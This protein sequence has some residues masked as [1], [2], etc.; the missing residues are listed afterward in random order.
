MWYDMQYALLS[1]NPPHANVHCNETLVCFKASGSPFLL[2]LH[3]TPLRYPAV[4][5][6]QKDPSDILFCMTSTFMWS[7]R[8]RWVRKKVGQSKTQN[9]ELSSS[10]LGTG[11]LSRERT[12]ASSPRNTPSGILPMVRGG[13][14]CPESRSGCL[15]VSAIPWWIGTVLLQC[16]ARGI[17]SYTGPVKV[18]AFYQDAQISTHIVPLSLCG[19]TGHKHPHRPRLASGYHHGSG[20]NLGDLDQYGSSSTDNSVYYDLRCVMVLRHWNG[21]RWL[22]RSQAN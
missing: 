1:N 8:H 11:T 20:D 5:P 17:V 7:C 2:N 15:R 18:E 4:F 13:A 3:Q 10:V 14:I 12:W 21:Q 16:T 6:R 22:P 19:N 9:V